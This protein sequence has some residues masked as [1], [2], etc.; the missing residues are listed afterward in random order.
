VQEVESVTAILFE[1]D[2]YGDVVKNALAPLIVA[3]ECE[4]IVA[5]T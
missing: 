1:N 2:E 5:Y 3:G 4:F